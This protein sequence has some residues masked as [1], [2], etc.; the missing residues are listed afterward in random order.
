MEQGVPLR[1]RLMSHPEARGGEVVSSKRLRA[2]GQC[3]V[4][5]KGRRQ[6]GTYGSEFGFLFSGVL[7]AEN[8]ADRPPRTL[9]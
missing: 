5:R 2:K 1:A 8:E 7:A 6:E 3:V 9:E 4:W